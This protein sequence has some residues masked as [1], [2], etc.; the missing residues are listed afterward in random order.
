MHFAKD[1]SKR[2]KLDDGSHDG[3]V[4]AD[5][6]VAGDPTIIDNGGLH[7]KTIQDNFFDSV[8]TVLRERG[9]GYER[10]KLFEGKNVHVDIHVKYELVGND[11]PEGFMRRNEEELIEFVMRCLKVV[12]LDRERVDTVEVN[13]WF[14]TGKGEINVVIKEV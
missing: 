13:K 7:N 11:H 6:Y 9:V 12:L 8:V 10:G 1:P 5:F 14:G 4:G 3:R 2:M